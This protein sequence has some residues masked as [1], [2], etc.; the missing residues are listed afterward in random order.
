VELPVVGETRICSMKGKGKSVPVH[1]MKE[2]RGEKI[3][4][5]LF[6]QHLL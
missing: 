4:A 1:S 6:L 5:G 2:Y 3:L